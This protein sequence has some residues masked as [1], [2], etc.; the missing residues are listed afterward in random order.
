M[1]EK[2]M[3]RLRLKSIRIALIAIL[4][5]TFTTLIYFNYLQLSES[6]TD[7]IVYTIVIDAGSTGS[8]IHVFKLNHE[9]GGYS[10]FINFFRRK[11][12][13]DHFFKD[14]NHFNRFD[15]KL[16]NEDLIIKVNPG[17]SSY[18]K[19]PDEVKHSIASI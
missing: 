16:I 12:Q 15:V 5:V 7:K 13:T 8:R 18:S 2:I 9:N 3:F 1:F 14:Q 10:N 17:L 11:I 19:N 6:S 4:L